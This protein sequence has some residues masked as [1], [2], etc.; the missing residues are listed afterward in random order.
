MVT[1]H[2]TLAAILDLNRF[3]VVLY[4]DA[5]GQIVIAVYRL[6]GCMDQSHSRPVF[7]TMVTL[8]RTLSAMLDLNRFSIVL[9]IDARGQIVMAISRLDGRMDQS[10][11]L[12]LFSCQ[13]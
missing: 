12:V 8:H 10:P 9:Y 3:S 1:L 2:R 6:G 5:R 11:H 7:M 13:C 4:I